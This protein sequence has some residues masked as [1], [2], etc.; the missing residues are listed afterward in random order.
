[1]RTIKRRIN[2][3][4]QVSLIKESTVHAGAA[5]H[6]VKC[7]LTR[8]KVPDPI[9]IIVENETGYHSTGE[10][11]QEDL[12]FKVMLRHMTHRKLE[13]RLFY[14]RHCLKSRE[15]EKLDVR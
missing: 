10:Y 2:C 9:S 4:V 15:R 8:H 14:M 13:A 12:K 7:L 1:M 3:L 6:S 11:R 5:L